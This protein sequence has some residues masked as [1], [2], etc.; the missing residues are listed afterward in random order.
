MIKVSV[1]VPIYNTEKYL[2]ECIDSILNQTLKDIELILV[3]DGSPD[4]CEGICYEF[5]KKDQRVIYI[6]QENQGV[7]VARNLGIEKAKGEY[8][9]CMDSDDTIEKSFL[10]TSY[11]VGVKNDSDLV[12]IGDYYKKRGKHPSALPTCAMLLK[13]EF[14]DKHFEIRY[15]VGIQPCEDGL[16]S[17]QLLALTDKI[18]FNDLGVYYYRQ[19]ETQ[20]HHNLQLDVLLKN[21]Y[22]WL[23][24]LQKFYREKLF[25][26]EKASFLL[27]FIEH[28]PFGLRYEKLSFTPKQK[29]ELF[30]LLHDFIKTNK[31]EPH[32]HNCSELF[33]HFCN[34]RDVE[35][36]ESKK[37]L[38]L[39]KQKLKLFFVGF[40]P[41]R[42]I[43][44][45]IKRRIKYGYK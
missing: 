28:E 31:L 17:H 24:I 21:I 41:L 9:Y 20:N 22:I 32:I 4:G 36:Y 16:F 12:V 14:L 30:L 29:E 44:K 40:I 35:D 13:K 6:Y 23:D 1:V 38:F 19:H 18:S 11:T 2:K 33:Q 10:E 5:I 25:L 7:S 42:R 3:N 45:K 34:S 37:K 43:R 15:P 26:I 39:L 27:K 8:I